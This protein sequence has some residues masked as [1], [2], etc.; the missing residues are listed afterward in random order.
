VPSV[1]EPLLALPRDG[2]PKFATVARRLTAPGSIERGL[3]SG[4]AVI[5]I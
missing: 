4:I 2:N 5:R 1:I 3:P